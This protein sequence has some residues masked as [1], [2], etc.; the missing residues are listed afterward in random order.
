MRKVNPGLFFPYKSVSTA[1][2]FSVLL[3]PVGLL[4][5]SFWGGLIMIILGFIIVSAGKYIVS[6]ILLWLICSI[7]SVRAVENYNLKIFQ[8]LSAHQA[9][10]STTE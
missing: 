6:L 8:R 1:L 10:H 4:Y 3:G 7:W 5:A 2:I 9:A